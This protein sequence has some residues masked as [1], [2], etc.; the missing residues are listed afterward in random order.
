M[1][2]VLD[3]GNGKVALKAEVMDGFGFEE[4]MKER[5]ELLIKFF[6]AQFLKILESCIAAIIQHA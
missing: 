2:S 1:L 6:L 3:V 4:N 5:I